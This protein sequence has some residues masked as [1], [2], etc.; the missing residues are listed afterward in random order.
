MGKLTFVGLGLGAKGITLEGVEAIREAD[1]AYLE[2]YT[3][4]H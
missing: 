4:P 2:Y 3:T 1:I